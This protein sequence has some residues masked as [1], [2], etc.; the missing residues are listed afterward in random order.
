MKFSLSWSKFVYKVEVS[1]NY[2]T[3]VID[4]SYYNFVYIR[5]THIG[6]ALTTFIASASDL[7]QNIKIINPFTPNSI[8]IINRAVY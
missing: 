4:L 3:Y 6:I 1:Q 5:Y 8:S 7:K 2:N